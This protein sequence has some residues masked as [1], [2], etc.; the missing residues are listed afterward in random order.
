M[1]AIETL[2]RRLQHP[3]DNLPLVVFRVAFGL[4]MFAGTV[5]FVANGWVEAFYVQPALHFS[6]YGFGWVKPL[7]GPWLYVVYAAVALLALGVAVGAFYRA[8]IT[9]FF[10]L[11]TYTELLDKT[12]YLN[13]YYFISVLSF[14]M[15]FLPLNRR[16]AVD[17]LIWPALRSEVAPAWTLAAL[18]LQLGLVYFFAGLAKL[19]PDWLLQALPLKIWLAAKADFPLLG[20]LFEAGWFAYAM[21]WSGALYDLSIVFWLL[22]RPTRLPAYLA[23][24]GFHLLTGL[25]FNIGMFP[26]IMIACTLVFFSADELGWVNQGFHKVKTIGRQ[27]SGHVERRT[28]NVASHDHT[29]RPTSHVPRPTSLKKLTQPT[30][31]V[32]LTAFFALQI[33]LPLRHW[34][35]PD[36]VLWTEEGYRFAWKVMLAEKT[37]HVTFTIT[38]PASG[39]S[40]DVFPAAYLTYQQEK[41]MS[42]QPDMI[43]EFAHYLE[44]QFRQQGF[45]DLEIRAEAYVS[46][47]GRPSRLLLDPTVDL[48]RRANTLAH[49]D[50]I[51]PSP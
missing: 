30:I 27:F 2:L 33:L 43:L 29:S 4:L 23:V 44:Q 32:V 31:F 15:I 11:F 17:G 48:T 8:S 46:L 42:F 6:Y 7:P 25:L 18:R 13:H 50:W 35:Y 3:T 49:Q 39:R 21:S 34:L 28:W 9:G 41:Q 51:L 47:N 37:G 45:A 26:Y 40:W 5:R 1:T 10:L 14:L 12:Y 22:Y 36:N 24:I 20:P 19:N 16:A 38:E